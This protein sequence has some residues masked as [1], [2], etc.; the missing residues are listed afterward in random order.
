MTSRLGHLLR[1]PVLGQ[2]GVD[3]GVEPAVDHQLPLS[4]GLVGGCGGLP[5]GGGGP[6]RRPGPARPAQ[7]SRDRAGGAAQLPGHSPQAGSRC[8]LAADLLSL[9]ERESWVSPHGLDRVHTY[10]GLM[11]MSLD[12][13]AIEDLRVTGSGFELDG[14]MAD[15]KTLKEHATNRPQH[16]M[17]FT[18]PHILDEKLAAKKFQVGTNSPDM[19]VM[20]IMNPWHGQEGL[21]H[22]FRLNLPWNSIQKDPSAVFQHGPSPKENSYPNEEADQRVGCHPPCCRNKDTSCHRTQRDG[23]ITQVVQVGTFDVNILGS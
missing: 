1:R 11:D 3:R 9:R 8:H 16:P 23:C 20:D 12:K 5:V 6:I 10:F 17:T 15:T 19:K 7:F 18:D 4:P 2:P 21:G 13:I 14:G 22:L